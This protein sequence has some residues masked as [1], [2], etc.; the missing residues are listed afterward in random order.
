MVMIRNDAFLLLACAFTVV[1]CTTEKEESAFTIH[2]EGHF[3][4]LNEEPVLLFGAGNWVVIPDGHRRHPIPTDFDLIHQAVSEYGA[5]SNRSAL[6]AFGNPEMMPWM[7]ENGKFDLDQ[8]NDDFWERLQSY[9]ESAE[10]YGIIPIIQI[11]DHPSAKP[12]ADDPERWESNPFNPANNVNDMGALKSE[13]YHPGYDFYNPDNEKLMDY[14]EAMVAKLL[15]ETHHYPGVIYQLDNEHPF[16]LTEWAD[17]LLNVFVEKEEEYGR[18]F[19]VSMMTMD[20]DSQMEFAQDERISVI[21]VFHTYQTGGYAEDVDLE[22]LFE[23]AAGFLY[24]GNGKP[25]ILGRGSVVPARGQGS[26]EAMRREWFTALLAGGQ[27]ASPR[28]IFDIVGEEPESIHIPT[29]DVIQS[30]KTFANAYPFWEMRP[31][32]DM[33]NGAFISVSVEKDIKVIYWPFPEEHQNLHLS[34]EN[35]DWLKESNQW[36]VTWYDPAEIEFSD[37]YTVSVTEG[38]IL[39]LEAPY[40][41]QDWALILRRQ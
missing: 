38:K 36:Q 20:R 34:T 19:M 13:N 25:I 29:L 15:D 27:I 11:F 8:W 39:E 40:S 1:C 22:T 31:M 16:G 26:V 5:N 28:M 6:Y 37:E 7:H 3:F 4:V 23:A 30:V 21:E 32:M 18:E 17:R 35:M 41:A 10:R 2:P 33:M 12:H 14:K 9:L 24:E